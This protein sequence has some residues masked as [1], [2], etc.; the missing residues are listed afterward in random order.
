[1]ARVPRANAII[2][3]KEGY[4]FTPD[5]RGII[6]VPGSRRWFLC[7]PLNNQK[8]KILQSTPLFIP[9]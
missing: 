1:M 8:I 4:Q 9:A 2:I 7:P 5:K 6:P 3:T